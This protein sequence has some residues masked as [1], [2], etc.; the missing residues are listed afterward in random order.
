MNICTVSEGGVSMQGGFPSTCV[1]YIENMLS[2][3]VCMLEVW[4]S[5]QRSCSIFMLPV[6]GKELYHSYISLHDMPWRKVP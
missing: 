5:K 3:T 4:C 1:A 6:G 2:L